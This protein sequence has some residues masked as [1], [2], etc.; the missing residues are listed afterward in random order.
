[1]LLASTHVA[2]SIVAGFSTPAASYVPRLQASRATVRAQAT[3][4]DVVAAT[5]DFLKTATGYYSPVDAAKLDD[6]FVF[7]APTIGP[8]N[9]K[10]YINTMTT[11]ETYVG[12]PDITPNAFGFTQDPDEPLK[13]IFWTRATGTFTQ[14]WNPYGKKLEALRIQP[15]GQTAKLPTECYSMTFTR[16]G[17]LRYLTAGF[18]VSKVEG[19]TG[20][21]GAVL[22]LFVNAGL[23]QLAQIA[24]DINFRAVG[25][26][27][28]NNVDSS[29]AKTV[30]NPEDLP[31]WYRAVEPPPEQ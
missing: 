4:V 9:K 24:L 31:A 29:V 21:F 10:D 2:I 15:N 30:S 20:G 14:P 22:A 1:M 17:K 19:N 18:V 16:E 8:L 26:W 3:A 25:T 11:L 7:R 28:A 6:D 12:Y 27:I 23:P 13:C 5:Q